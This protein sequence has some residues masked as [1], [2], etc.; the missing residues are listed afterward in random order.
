MP[1]VSLRDHAC[2]LMRSVGAIVGVGLEPDADGACG[3]RID[4]R[5]TL[6]LRHESAP[7]AL[8]AYSAVG[9]LP[10][11]SLEQVLRGL[12]E[13]NHVWDGSR[14]ATWALRGN[15]VVLSR[16]WPLPGIE[17]EALAADL[18]VFVQVAVDGQQRLQSRPA[19]ASQVLLSAAHVAPAGAGMWPPG[20]RF[21]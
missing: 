15:E 13:A 7:P 17:A 2:A 8:L 19:A 14:G 20:A 11:G 9:L 18:A 16:L 6:T 12:L 10:E 4:D 21:A 5:L 3:L 1:I